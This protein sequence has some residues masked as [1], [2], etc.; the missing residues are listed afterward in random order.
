LKELQNSAELVAVAIG[1]DA[2]AL[3]KRLMEYKQTNNFII[4]LIIY[5]MP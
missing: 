5:K 1:Q 3:E 4:F 2:N